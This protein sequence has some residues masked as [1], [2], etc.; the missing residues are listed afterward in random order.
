MSDAVATVV[1]E[2]HYTPQEVA[3]ILKVTPQTVQ[4]IFRQVPGV[5]EFGSRETL[6]KRA[7]MFIRIP[8]SVF[9]RWH[10]QNRCCVQYRIC[11]GGGIGRRTSLRGWR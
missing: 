3:E 2:H 6:R 4:R 11:A 1:T 8:K 5:V 10:E 7:R 9:V